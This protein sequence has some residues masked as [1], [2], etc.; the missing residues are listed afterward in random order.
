MYI[1]HSEIVEYNKFTCRSSYFSIVYT[2]CPTLYLTRHFFN[3][4]NSNENIASKFEQE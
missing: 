4:S 1:Y 2:G 3:N